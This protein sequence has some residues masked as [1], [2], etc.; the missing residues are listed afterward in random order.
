MNEEIKSIMTWT[1]VRVHYKASNQ[2]L[3]KLITTSLHNKHKTRCN[4]GGRNSKKNEEKISHFDAESWRHVTPMRG[5]ALF[6]HR[7]SILWFSKLCFENFDPRQAIKRALITSREG[8]RSLPVVL[9]KPTRTYRSAGRIN[10]PPK[11]CPS[12]KQFQA[13]IFLF[14]STRKQLCWREF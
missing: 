6:K 7:R 11:P 10:L 5:L 8:R 12:Q 3:T 1:R 13:S 2:R 4:A 14:S 9:R